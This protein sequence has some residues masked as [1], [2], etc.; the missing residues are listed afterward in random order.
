MCNSRESDRYSYLNIAWPSD[1]KWHCM[2]LHSNAQAKYQRM[3]RARKTLFII[4]DSAKLPRQPRT[5]LTDRDHHN[6]NDFHVLAS[7]IE[8]WYC[9]AIT[10]ILAIL[11]SFN[12]LPRYFISNCTITC[13][14]Q[15]LLPCK[16]RILAQIL[17]RKLKRHSFYLDHVQRITFLQ[18]LMHFLHLLRLHYLSHYIITTKW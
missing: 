7:S 9:G 4:Q 16:F 12:N 10:Q 14:F 11:Y 15:S 18:I 17:L 3:F 1:T 2:M 5:L 6:L 8:L 13:F